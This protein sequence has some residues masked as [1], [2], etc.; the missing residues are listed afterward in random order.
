MTS[1]D[2]KLIAGAIKFRVDKLL[3]EREQLSCGHNRQREI[4]KEIGT[5]ERLV[6]DDLCIILSSDND[7]FNSQRF[8]DACGLS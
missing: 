3:I 8:F 6:S 4:L 5:I 1:K 7:N 2:Y